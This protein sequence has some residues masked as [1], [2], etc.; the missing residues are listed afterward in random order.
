MEIKLKHIIAAA[1]IIVAVARYGHYR[2]TV[3]A[4]QNEV[5]RLSVEL[6]HAQIPLQRDTI[7]D[8]IEVVTQT[9][10]EVVPK[11]LSEALAADE[12]L[13]KDLE[14]KIRQLEAMQTTTIVTADSVPALHKPTDSLFFYSDLWAD[15][16]LSLKDTMFYYNI[17][18]SLSTL[19]Y[20]EYRHHFLW[21]RWGTKGYRLKIVNFNPH[22][23]VVYSRYIKTGK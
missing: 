19:V 12:Q 10:V 4:L 2:N 6:S 15:I 5:N 16:R 21:W 18:D 13:I 23:S 9:V 14:L 7:H 20:R 22:A 3:A 11:K 8:S 1:V 17:R